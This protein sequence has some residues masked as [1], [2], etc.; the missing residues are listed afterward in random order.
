MTL[1][2]SIVVFG[3]SVIVSLV[4]YVWATLSRRIEKIE[5]MNANPV[6]LA[7]IKEVIDGRF[8]EFRIE[9]YKSGVL[10]PVTTKTRKKQVEEA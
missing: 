3:L 2:I 4:S 1:P 8:N 10:K 7:Q 9:L 6:T 5:K